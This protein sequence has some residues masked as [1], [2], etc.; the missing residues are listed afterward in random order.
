[1]NTAFISLLISFAGF[2]LAFAV[3]QLSKQHLR[4]SWLK[5]Y[6]EIHTLF[7]NDDDI[8]TIRYCL[9]YER[10]YRPLKTALLHDRE[11]EEQSTDN[12]EPLRE[13]EYILL[14]KLDKFLNLFERAEGIRPELSKYRDLWQDLFFQVWL[15]YCMD[16]KRPEL[17]WYMERDYQNLVQLHQKFKNDPK[18]RIVNK[19]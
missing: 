1:M 5:N 11:V 6:G 9:A 15:N 19:T 2:V 12:T 8:K 4:E 16:P 14:D 3:Y 10:A 13:K 7:W 18:S 17:I